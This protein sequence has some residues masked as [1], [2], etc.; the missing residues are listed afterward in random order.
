VVAQSEAQRSNLA[1]NFG[2]DCS[3]VRSCYDHDGHTGHPDGVI[4][5]VGNIIPVKRPELFIDL[6]RRLP[7]YRFKMIGGADEALIAP[8]RR[9]AADLGNIEFAGFVPYAEVESHFDRASI[10]VNTSSNEG[11]PNTFLQAW[12]RGIPTVSM[13]D[14][15]AYLNS[16]RVGE[17]VNSVE[18]MA[19]TISKIK[20][21]PTVWQALGQ[22]SRQYFSQHFSTSRAVDSYEQCFRQAL[23]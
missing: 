14:P 11:F 21:S 16:D 4:L 23:A 15:G 1:K 3:V 22:A 13:I 12:S 18:Q 19:Q 17:V 9:L 6:V 7:N 2:R 8:L 10:L 5:W 20:S